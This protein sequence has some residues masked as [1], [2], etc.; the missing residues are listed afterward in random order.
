MQLTALILLI[1]LAL[2]I[3]TAITSPLLLTV[4]I[5]GSA[6]VVGVF[7]GF[8]DLQGEDTKNKDD[9]DGEDDF[10]SRGKKGK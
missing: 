6:I 3:Y 7:G 1:P 9:M 8:D 4:C 5:L 10:E 2:L